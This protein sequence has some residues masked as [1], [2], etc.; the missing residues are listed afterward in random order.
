MICVEVGI[1]SA[2]SLLVVGMGGLDTGPMTIGLGLLLESWSGGRGGASLALI[3]VVKVHAKF[4]SRLR[5]R[6][7]GLAAASSDGDDAAEDEAGD[8]DSD[9][10][11]ISE[12]VQDLLVD[13]V[14]FRLASRVQF[15]WI[16]VVVIVED[17][18]GVVK[19]VDGVTD[20]SVCTG[21]DAAG[22]HGGGTFA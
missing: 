15:G 13:V 9:D 6:W 2:V 20:G 18:V 1:G 7:H 3:V 14:E 4:R 16:V 21:D 11:V 17:V 19:A 12:R 5:Y 10:R 22:D 8:E